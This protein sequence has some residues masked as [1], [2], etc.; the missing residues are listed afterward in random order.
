MAEGEQENKT[1]ENVR[2]GVPEA[3]ERAAVQQ[4]TISSSL[5]D[6]R[7]KQ[8]PLS[9]LLPAHVTDLQPGTAAGELPGGARREVFQP[10]LHLCTE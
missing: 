1:E 6:L 4:V 5:Y 9:Y 3:D 2:P 7:G 10:Q 8:R